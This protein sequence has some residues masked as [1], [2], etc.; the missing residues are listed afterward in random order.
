MDTP[1]EKRQKSLDEQFAGF[2]Y[3]NGKLFAENL[4]SASFDRA[5]RET[6]LD[7]TALDWGQI[8][9][10]IFGSLFQS[11]MD[12]KARRDLGAHYTSEHNIR[13]ALGPLF[14]DDLWVELGKLKA[15]G[16]SNAKR[17]LEFHAKL[18]GIRILDPACG[19]GN[20]LVVAYQELRLLELDLL[21]EMHKHRETG[22]LDVGS[23]VFV[24]DFGELGFY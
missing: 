8:S 1:P 24:T 10:A 16:K 6:L 3:V 18:A 11:I 4:R 9:P 21:R 23:I 22:F 2:P 15:S 5:M 13:K 19:C 7:C 12:A 14:L 20:F 17:L